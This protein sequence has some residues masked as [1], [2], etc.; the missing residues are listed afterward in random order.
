MGFSSNLYC[1]NFNF[2]FCLRWWKCF[3]VFFT[4]VF[5]SLK[6]L[7]IIFPCISFMSMIIFTTS[8]SFFFLLLICVIYDNLRCF[9]FLFKLYTH[10]G[11][12]VSV[13]PLFHHCYVTNLFHF[14]HKNVLTISTSLILSK[15]M[16]IP[17]IFFSIGS[18]ISMS[19]VFSHFCQ[20]SHFCHFFLFCL[21]TPMIPY[22]S[23]AFKLFL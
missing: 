20:F 16:L 1:F 3:L 12:N 23:I 15:F 4:S 17:Y 9:Q 14:N 8:N 22:I 11:H 10:F 6:I 18:A 2:D 19:T 13:C 7:S 21:M 5:I